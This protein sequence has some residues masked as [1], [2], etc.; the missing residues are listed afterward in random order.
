MRLVK[1]IATTVYKLATD[2]KEPPVPL[3]VS[4]ELVS[5][6]LLCMLEF[7]IKLPSKQKFISFHRP[8]VKLKRNVVYCCKSLSKSSFREL[9]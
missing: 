4:A 6:C 9:D 5:D 7:W 3:D 1:A 2:G 8:L